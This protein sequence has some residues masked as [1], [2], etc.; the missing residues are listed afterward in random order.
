MYKLFI[1]NNIILNNNNNIYYFLSIF[2]FS[3]N[4]YKLTITIYFQFLET[5]YIS[6][7]EDRVLSSI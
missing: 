4:R 2:F 5:Y 6:I 3:H 7:N 1:K